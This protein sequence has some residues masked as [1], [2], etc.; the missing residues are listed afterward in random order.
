M[1]SSFK[2]FIIM[3]NYRNFGERNGRKCVDYVVSSSSSISSFW[4][5]TAFGP[6][7]R[8]S[9][10]FL[11]KLFYCKS[12]SFSQRDT[13]GHAHNLSLSMQEG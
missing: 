1:F 11:K 10:I 9:D 13:G 2:V 6:G 4:N 8:G 5:F 12:L 7:V 3:V